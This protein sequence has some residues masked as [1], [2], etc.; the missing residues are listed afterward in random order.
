MRAYRL[1]DYAGPSALELVEVQAIGINH[2][3]LLLIK[4]LYQYRPEFPVVPGCEIAGT[5][6]VAPQRVGP[7]AR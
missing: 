6:L 2:P 3:D 7:R 4:G 1:T 5:I